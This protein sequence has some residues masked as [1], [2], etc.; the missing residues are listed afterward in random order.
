MSFRVESV[1]VRADPRTWSVAILLA[2]AMLGGCRTARGI[3]DEPGQDT[4][5]APERGTP[6]ARA[7]LSRDD[8]LAIATVIVT[9]FFRP[10][11]GEARWLDPRPLGDVR[12]P[13]DSAAIPDELWAIALRTSI[14]HPRVCLLPDDPADS[15]DGCRG[16]TG[17]VLRFSHAYATTSNDA[18]IYA[19]WTPAHDEGDVPVLGQPSFEMRF[20][21]ERVGGGGWRIVRQ[22]AVQP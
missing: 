16:R 17:G 2:A 22:R 21:M 11:R 3:V 18:V 8:Q 6:V 5:D 20:T 14:G 10:T 7:A 15:E 12:S 9:R 1:S 13:A 4:R 19:R